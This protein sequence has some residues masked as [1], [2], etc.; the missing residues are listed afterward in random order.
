VLNLNFED[1]GC[2]HQFSSQKFFSTGFHPWRIKDDYTG[3]NRVFLKKYSKEKRFVF[4]GEC[5][6]DKYV[7]TALDKQISVFEEQVQLSEEIQK[8]LIIHCAGR[9]NELLEIKK[10]IRPAQRWIVH[11]FRNKPQL[12]GQLLSAGCDL[13]FGEYFNAESLRITPFENLFLETDESI[14]SI[15]AIYTKAAAIKNCKVEDL[16]AGFEL[17]RE[18]NVLNGLFN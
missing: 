12:A 9:F 6:L 4:I 8:P 16:S 13:S 10:A 15:S 2:F 5:G 18:L 11:G 7:D 1:A 17:L 3:E 14:L